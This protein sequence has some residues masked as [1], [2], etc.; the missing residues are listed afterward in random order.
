[1]ETSSTFWNAVQ[2][3]SAL[4]TSEKILKRLQEIDWNAFEAKQDLHFLHQLLLEL[5]EKEGITELHHWV[6]EQ[7]NEVIGLRLMHNFGHE[8]TITATALSPD[9]QYLVTGSDLTSNYDLGGVVQVW[10]L[11]SGRCINTFTY[12]PW[13]VGSE[14]NGV[15]G[16]FKW[17]PNGRELGVVYAE[18]HVTHMNPFAASEDA[19][20]PATQTCIAFLDGAGYA[21]YAWAPDGKTMAF[22]HYFGKDELPIGIQYLFGGWAYQS[23]LPIV[24][25]DEDTDD[26][27]ACAEDEVIPE[28]VMPAHYSEEEFPFLSWIGWSKDGQRIFGNSFDRIYDSGQGRAYCVEAHS[29]RPIYSLEVGR[30]V[31]WSTNDRFFA[32]TLPAGGGWVSTSPSRRFPYTGFVIADA[33]TGQTLLENTTLANIVEFHWHDNHLAVITHQDD[34]LPAMV[35]IYYVD[36]PICSFVT[37]QHRKDGYAPFPDR[38][39]WSWAP[40]GKRGVVLTQA[41]L[42]CWE[43]DEKPSLTGTFKCANDIETILWGTGETIACVGKKRVE[44]LHM[45]TGKILYTQLMTGSREELMVNQPSPLCTESK[46]YNLIFPT[47]PLFPLQDLTHKDEYHWLAAFPSGTQG[48][49]ICPETLQKDLDDHLQFVLV[50]LDESEAKAWPFRWGKCPVCPNL[51]AALEQHLLDHCFDKEALEDLKSTLAQKVDTLP[52]DLSVIVPKNMALPPLDGL[53][54]SYDEAIA[55]YDVNKGSYIKDEHF[56][57]QTLFL[58]LCKQPQQALERAVQAK[59]FYIQAAALSQAALLAA[60]TGEVKNAWFFVKELEIRLANHGSL[61]DWYHTYVYAPLYGAYRL[62]G[63]PKEAEETLAK[64]M[65]AIENESNAFQKWRLLAEAHFHCG[66]FDQVLKIYE[67]HGDKGGT[68]SLSMELSLVILVVAKAP[69]EV[70]DQLLAILA[71]NA[72]RNNDA[73]G[74]MI[75][76][77]FFREKHW[78]GLSTYLKRLPHNAHSIAHILKALCK[79]GAKDLAQKLLEEIAQE[80]GRF[81][82]TFKGKEELMNVRALIEGELVHQEV[83]ERVNEVVT[84]IDHYRSLSTW[85]SK[86]NPWPYIYSLLEATTYLEDTEGTLALLP[87]FGTPLGILKGVIEDEMVTLG[88]RK[89]LWQHFAPTFQAQAVETHLDLAHCAYIV[90]DTVILNQCIEQL[91]NASLEQSGR[92]KADTLENLTTLLLACGQVEEAHHFW[93]KQAV[94][95]RLDKA[96]E[97][98]VT[99]AREGQLNAIDA[100]IK[101]MNPEDQIRAIM[102][103][104]KQYIKERIPN[105]KYIHEL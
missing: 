51:E 25:E 8:A 76:A 93:E 23:I 47:M 65:V 82:D 73:L 36:Q 27:E 88:F 87:L 77:R 105:A 80:Q 89:K 2:L 9:G 78:S 22:A 75:E 42:E 31:A 35:H 57:L 16:T 17:S 99:L 59:E 20:H 54:S 43:V 14:R 37:G 44:F 38:C 70:V 56:Y 67:A 69:L 7:L 62:L 30:N 5:E 32:Y 6:T 26:Y 83:T 66:E 85:Q 95:V 64:A 101:R 46:D 71:P 12:M 53:I 102:Q 11:A 92:E 10:E 96:E 39:L 74:E 58:T 100:M 97:L 90:G 48:P 49:V 24:E 104:L 4:D 55:A 52:F 84:N 79:T 45:P 98:L 68:F 18:N 81:E 33:Q 15:A 103:V 1:M 21:D 72:T 28:Q 61:R 34:G 29:G 86:E 60:S 13:G 40:D 94:S 41:G 3:T 50:Y 19:T 63:K 91:K